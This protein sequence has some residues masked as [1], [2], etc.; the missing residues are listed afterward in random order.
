MN[1]CKFIYMHTFKKLLLTV[2]YSFVLAAVFSQQ[3]KPRVLKPAVKQNINYPKLKEEIRTLYVDE[4]HAAVI[5][6]ASIYLAKFTKDTAVSFQKAISHISLMQYKAG[7]N[8]IKKF[9]NN[10]IDSASK[11]I[12]IIAFSVPQKNILTSGMACADESIKLLPTAPYGYF[13]KG[14]IYSDSGYHNKALPFMEKMYLA[15]RNNEEKIMFGYFYPKELALNQQLT[16]A[17]IV[18]NDLYLKYPK[19]RDIIYNYAAIYILNESYQ[20]AIEKYDELVTMF[21]DQPVYKTFKVNALAAMGNTLAACNLADSIIAIDDQYRQL[22]FRNKCS[23]YFAKPS[24]SDMAT[25]AWQV[26][27]FGGTYNFTVSSII[28]NLK[29]SLSFNWLM[30]NGPGMNGHI[31]LTAPALDTASAQNNFFG[32][33]L[34]IAALTDKTTI[35]LSKT[36]FTK[37]ENE[38]TCKM[39]VGAG[40]EIYDVVKDETVNRDKEAFDNEVKVKGVARYLNTI[41]IKNKEGSRQLWILKDIQ[42]PL[43]VKMDIG[44]SLVL[45][46]ID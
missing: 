31:L 38:G 7:F 10:N 17:L 41:H 45:K 36:V 42:N 25:A 4:K 16:E 29:D 19:Q 21:P 34:K 32:P 9:Y 14:G 30:T 6:K 18:I 40:Q 15:C 12:A 22:R 8:V 46:S 5:G 2:L 27:T 11:Y 20:K 39:D 28:G 13:V 26:T 1:Y 43:I 44:F 3:T 23:G 33:D 35:W 37:L 24:L